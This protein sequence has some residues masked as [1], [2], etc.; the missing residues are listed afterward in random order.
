MVVN[1]IAKFDNPGTSIQI[2]VNDEVKSKAERIKT[3]LTGTLPVTIAKCP[4][5]TVDT[6]FQTLPRPAFIRDDY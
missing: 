2:Q 5:E 6:A 3:A 4:R 1:L